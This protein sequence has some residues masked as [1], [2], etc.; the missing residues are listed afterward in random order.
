MKT[1]QTVKALALALLGVL[2]ACGAHCQIVSDDFNKATLTKTLW[3]WID[4]VGDAQYSISG[5]GSSDV[6]LLMSVPEGAGHDPWTVNAS[7]QLMQTAPNQDFEVLARFDTLP[8]LENQQEGILVPDGTGT[9]FLRFCLQVQGG[10]L[11]AFMLKVQNGT[12]G[13]LSGTTW[14]IGI[15]SLTMPT[16]GATTGTAYLKLKRAGDQW[17]FTISPNGETWETVYQ[18]VQQAW[19]VAQIG[20]YVGDG[21]TGFTA[22]L[23]YFF[24]TASP[25]LNEDGQNAPP[26][27]A[28]AVPSAETSYALPTNIV[29]TATASDAD[30]S[31]K[32]VEFYAGATLLGAVT[33]SPYSYTWNNPPPG[34]YAVSAKATD[35]VGATKSSPAVPILVLGTGGKPVSDDFSKP[36]LNPL[37][38]TTVNPNG[39]GTFQIVGAGSADDHLQVGVPGGANHD[40][41]ISNQ[42]LSVI[43]PVADTN[44]QIEAKFDSLPNTA[45]QDEGLIVQDDAGNFLRFDVMDDGSTSLKAFVGVI[46]NGNGTQ[47][48]R[49]TVSDVPLPTLG[50]L[51]TVF[52]RVRRLSDQWTFS[53]SPDAK[54]WTVQSSFLQPM[55]ISQVGLLA[56]NND[57]SGNAYPPPFTVLVDYFFNSVA[58][59]TLEDGQGVNTPPSVAMIGPAEHT[60]FPAPAQITL[61]ADATDSDGSI[62]K[63]EFYAGTNRLGSATVAPYRFTWNATSAGIYSVSAVATDNLGAA[64][65]STNSITVLVGAPGLL[66]VSD[67][68]NAASIKPIWTNVDPVGDGAFQMVGANTGNAHLLI[69][70]PTGNEHDGWNP[71]NMLR[72][73]QPVTDQDFELE[74]K[75][76]TLP[77]TTSGSSLFEG[78]S[79]EDANGTALRWD[80]ALNASWDSGNPKLLHWVGKGIGSNPSGVASI[81]MNEFPKSTN[82]AGTIYLRVRRQGTTWTSFTSAD[83]GVWT[84]R[85]QFSDPLIPAMAGVHAGN[86]CGTESADFTASVDYFF[87]SLAPIALEDGQAATRPN[88][89]VTRSG[90]SLV[91]SWP[92]IN[93]GYSLEG[94]TSLINPNWLAV[95]EA[96]IVVGG[97]NTATLPVSNSATFYR[98]RK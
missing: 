67:D 25:I 11:I 96:I 57:P 30:G 86:C 55:Q 45:N 9:N 84:Q 39:D 79:V 64:K 91:I 52:L 59:I 6:H 85:A 95:N 72:L 23:D 32:K 31:V 2:A 58:P 93:S 37:L 94:S 80:A 29:L 1:T 17:T 40:P 19:T 65:A 60:L 10:K 75:F 82:S 4:P 18:P 22:A 98:L 34:L 43:Q 68:F 61:T 15:S 83:G 77:P 51:G 36:T 42:G 35:N 41:W 26:T 69:V 50:N 66:P 70:V 49:T 38:W 24:N 21:G 73:L 7:A 12:G 46:L 54:V 74:A 63:V 16:D 20:P 5:Y 90:G 13:P 33:A 62:S 92:A 78:I 44:F 3:T 56:G 71:N 87:N 89:A 28:L 14:Q 47:Q 48:S 8:A 88:L 53:T 81:T 97:Q 27:I 76:D